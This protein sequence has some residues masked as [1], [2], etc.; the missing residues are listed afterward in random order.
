MKI[1]FCSF[2]PL[3]KELGTPKALLELSE[4]LRDLGW[5]CDLMGREEILQRGQA[6]PAGADQERHDL[7]FMEATRRLLHERAADYDVVEYEHSSLPFA[8]AEFASQTLMVAKSLLL[9]HHFNR[10]PTLPTR[11]ARALLAK[12]LRGARQTARQK[13]DVER[14][15][16]TT[17]EADLVNVN[18][19]DAKAE[20]IKYGI[21]PDKIEVLAY[22]IDEERRAL[23]DAIPS[24]PPATPV[25]A[26][27]GSF[28]Y[29]KG[30]GDF[31][32]LVAAVVK[33]VPDVRFRLLGT[34]GLFPTAEAVKAVF[35]RPLQE[36][37]EVV[38]RF[39]SNELPGLLRECSVGVFPSY[40]E[41]F[42]F[43]VLE[44]LAASI[45]VV[46]YDAPGPPMMLPPSYLV[47]PGDVKA[48]SARVVELLQNPDA[49]TQARVWAKARSQEFRWTTIARETS[50]IYQ[51][52]L[53]ALRSRNR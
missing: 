46:A 37:I 45:P 22:A 21:A 33:A 41:G 32:A 16:V 2:T 40:W 47:A 35:S 19:T 53:S 10:M 23:F 17:R 42:G 31:P 44:M 36:R 49:L 18:N 11:N 20:L 25:V 7:A 48:M 12:A 34:A 4:G 29:R 27:V 50:E 3:T 8:R 9:A 39:H 13:R 26:F 51:R 43:G 52:H 15:T 24:A 30:A 14:A 28:D 1:L 38:P 5:Q 6:P